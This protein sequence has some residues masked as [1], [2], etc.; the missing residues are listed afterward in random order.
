MNVQMAWECERPA[1]RDHFWT[2]PRSQESLWESLEDPWS[3]GTQTDG[4]P[5]EEVLYGPRWFKGTSQTR[6]DD[7]V[8]RLE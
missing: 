2:I 3:A 4:G 5:E 7:A 1:E 8:G 6:E